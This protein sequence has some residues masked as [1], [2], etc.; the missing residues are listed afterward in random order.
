VRLIVQGAMLTSLGRA[1]Q[2]ALTHLQDTRI[3][4]LERH[5]RS[6]AE[7]LQQ[8]QV[9]LA[10]HAAMLLALDNELRKKVSSSEIDPAI[11]EMNQRLGKAREQMQKAAEA[12]KESWSKTQQEANAAF[13]KLQQ[14]ASEVTKRLKNELGLDKDNP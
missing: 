6:G 5:L 9:V 11:V 10:D 12:T 3:A 8:A 14:S 4:M 1:G 13:E 2:Q 7:A